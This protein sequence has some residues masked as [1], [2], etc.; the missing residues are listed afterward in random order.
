MLARSAYSLGIS[1]WLPKN[2]PKDEHYIESDSEEA[3]L[4]G[5]RLEGWPLARPSPLPSFETPTFGRLLGMRSF[6]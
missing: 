1:P 3:A 5:G 2:G 6:Q 4:L